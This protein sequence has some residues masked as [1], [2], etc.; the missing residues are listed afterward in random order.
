[1]AKL[2]KCSICL[3]CCGCGNNL[4]F[5]KFGMFE[6]QVFFDKVLEHEV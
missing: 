4:E 2:G 1:M 5:L 6:Y 3:K